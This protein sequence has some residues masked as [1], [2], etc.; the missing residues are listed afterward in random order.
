MRFL[1]FLEDTS[2]VRG[3]LVCNEDGE[4]LHVSGSS[5][6][7][8]WTALRTCTIA[9]DFSVA[10][11][12]AGLGAL[13]SVAV[14]SAQSSRLLAQSGASIAVIDLEPSRA[15]ADLEAQLQENEWAS[16]E[17]AVSEVPS[18]M[19]DH[20]TLPPQGAPGAGKQGSA[21]GPQSPALVT[22]SPV[23]AVP[24]RPF[25]G[26]PAIAGRAVPRPN[27]SPNAPVPRA[28]P[29][30]VSATAR[31]GRPPPPT[32]ATGATAA[33]AEAQNPTA[34]A[35]DITSTRRAEQG[36]PSSALLTGSLATFALPD[37][38][39]FLRVGQRTGTLVCASDAGLGAIHIKR[40]RITGAASPGVPS[41]GDW[42]VQRGVLTQ[43]KLH[44]ALRHHTQSGTKTQLG[45]TLVAHKLVSQESLQEALMVHVGAVIRKLMTWESGAFTFDPASAETAEGADIEIEPQNVLLNIFK[46]MD[47][48]RRG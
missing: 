31:P 3:F 36:T 14:R 40:G 37:L 17:I 42:L 5:A 25:Q 32:R 12:I 2:G 10:G 29:P 1:A 33:A 9:R 24:P 15:T 6:S 26:L 35:E 21:A 41:I 27:A 23:V 46:E 20:E 11:A 38:L 48:S 34:T 16:A 8:G 7:S 4:Q 13:S 43:E 39:E 19:S 22:P 28:V 30:G 45:G 18:G 44:E 47:D